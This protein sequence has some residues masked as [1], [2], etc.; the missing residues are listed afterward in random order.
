MIAGW[1]ASPSAAVVNGLMYLFLLFL[2]RLVVRNQWAAAVLLV[3]VFGTLVSAQRQ[4]VPGALR[5]M[6][7]LAELCAVLL[8]IRAGLL[9]WIVFFSSRRS[10]CGSLSCPAWPLRIQASE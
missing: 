1:I 5:L 2:L 4:D 7:Y 6:P 10:C 8:M 3:V 9:P